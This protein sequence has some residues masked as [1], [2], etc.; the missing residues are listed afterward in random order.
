MLAAAR[1]YGVGVLMVS[2]RG[3]LTTNVVNSR[4]PHMNP[5]PHCVKS[6]W[7]PGG[8]SSFVHYISLIC[9]AAFYLC[10]RIPQIVWCSEVSYHRSRVL[11]FPC[12]HSCGGAFPPTYSIY[13]HMPQL[14]PGICFHL[15]QTLCNAV[16]G[17]DFKHV[18]TLSIFSF[19]SACYWN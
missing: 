13:C 14:Q 19:L 9:T 16:V 1:C 17:F 11:I 6:R 10:D 15:L 3:A 7:I 4:S 8:W 5:W 18:L 2:V 12:G